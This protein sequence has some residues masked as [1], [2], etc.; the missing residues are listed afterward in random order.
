MPFIY[1]ARDCDGNQVD[2]AL[3]YRPLPR[4][5]MDP[6]PTFNDLVNDQ[7]DPYPEGAAWAEI[8]GESWDEE[9]ELAAQELGFAPSEALL[10]KQDWEKGA[11]RFLAD[12]DH[13]DWFLHEFYAEGLDRAISLDDFKH[14][15]AFTYA[16][17]LRTDGAYDDFWA[18]LKRFW[19]DYA[20]RPA[21]ATMSWPELALGRMLLSG[22]N[23]SY[24]D[25]FE[26]LKPLC[27][28]SA[29]GDNPVYPLYELEEECWCDA[30]DEDTRVTCEVNCTFS[31]L[32]VPIDT[33]TVKGESKY[34]DIELQDWE[35][36][37]NTFYSVEPV[38]D[39]VEVLEYFGENST[40][41][42][43]LESCSEAASPPDSVPQDNSFGDYAVFLDEALYAQFEYEEDAETLARMM[44]ATS[45]R[46][47]LGH[48]VEVRQKILDFEEDEEEDEAAYREETD[49][50][51]IDNW[52][53]V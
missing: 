16:R 24:P 3:Y 31:I 11:S 41:E 18:Q 50:D 33:W 1:K 22:Y 26:L 12:P 43:S 9:A 42:Q 4:E 10:V 25:V 15:L 20:A 40:V 27:K 38:Y 30:K 2:V 5:P 17:V 51:D 46:Q 32:G 7:D 21:D 6:E 29:F 34:T 52:Q 19:P 37:V 44:E 14:L 36:E 45:G 28:V 53:P 35:I 13:F 49:W 8:S 47:Y 39:T 48:N 23:K